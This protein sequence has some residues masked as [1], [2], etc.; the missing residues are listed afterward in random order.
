M[1][2]LVT[3]HRPAA[4]LARP[5]PSV[6]VD[7]HPFTLRDST[8]G[9]HSQPP[10][11]PARATPIIITAR[12]RSLDMSAE[13]ERERLLDENASSS[14][15]SRANRVRVALIATAV[16]VFGLA[17]SYSASRAARTSQSALSTPVYVISDERPGRDADVAKVTV[18]R[19]VSYLMKYRGASEAT[20][21]GTLRASPA[22]FPADWPTTLN[23]ATTYANF[24]R[25]GG[26]VKTRRW[27]RNIRSRRSSRRRRRTG[28]DGFF[29]QD[30]LRHHLGC[31]LSHL[32]AWEMAM[33]DGAQ[34][35]VV[36]ESDA[37]NLASVNVLDYD[38]LA[39]RLPADTDMVWMHNH[40][41]GS[42]PFVMKFPSKATGKWTGGEFVET[43][44]ASS[45][46]YLYRFNKRSGWAGSSNIMDETR[47]R[48][49]RDF[50]KEHGGD[51]IDAWLVSQCLK[52]CEHHN[53]LNLVCYDAQTTP[54]KKEHI[55]GFI[56]GWYEDG[57]DRAVD[58]WMYL[59]LD[60]DHLRYNQLGCE[61]GAQD[62][63]E[64]GA[65]FIGFEAE[66][67]KFEETVE[68]QLSY[69][70]AV[71]AGVNPCATALPLRRPTSMAV[72]S[73]EATLSLAERMQG[74]GSFSSMNHDA[75]FLRARALERQRLV[76]QR[77]AE[78]R[79]ERVSARRARRG[80][81][82]DHDDETEK[83]HTQKTD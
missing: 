6:S 43:N 21:R 16:A 10:P 45:S 2:S 22:V 47:P 5:S 23:L 7:S 44:N 63:I 4:R 26:A 77:Q 53:C 48:K 13:C 39:Q 32:G 29:C 57:V 61:R 25:D 73:A 62:F 1:T 46:V 18:D 74:D 83:K 79:A 17:G 11:H 78:Q 24:Y 40:R 81:T 65:Y 66:D 33:R 27:S 82:D 19:A 15:E 12:A 69:Q 36:W 38:D 30:G 20:A 80:T 34:T 58:P 72:A 35:F 50:I 64:N 71:Q 60:V 70:A 3:R 42:G 28:A 55:G 56:P 8:H 41:G 37:M 54:I 68:G 52:R 67:E 51:M 76:E 59:P 9:G 49:V 31:F 14:R 75:E